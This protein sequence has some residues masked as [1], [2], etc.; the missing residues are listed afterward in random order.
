MRP[1]APAH[2]A[3]TR[4]LVARVVKLVRDRSGV[5]AVEFALLLPLMLTLYVGGTE[6]SQGTAISRKV[7]LTSRTVT[8]LVSRVTTTSTSDLQNSLNA[9]VAA[10]APYTPGQMSVTV[11][12]IAIDKNGKATINW[13]C[14]YQ[15]TAHQTGD[16]VTLPASMAVPSTYLIWGESQYDFTPAIGYVL[17]GTLHLKDEVYMVPRMSKNVGF[18]PANC[19]SFS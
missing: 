1:A 4:G 5:S 10:I 16:T 12:Q 17:T 8:D 2:P 13:S 7:T 19:P 14:S 11:S 3:F 9:A 18:T 15:G 6:L